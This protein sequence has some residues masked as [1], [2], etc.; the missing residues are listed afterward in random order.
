MA[1]R[2]SDILIRDFETAPR[3]YR[4]AAVYGPLV[5]ELLARGAISE[6]CTRPRTFEVVRTSTPK[7]SFGSKL[8]DMLADATAE[9]EDVPAELAAYW[10]AP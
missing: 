3:S 6:T 9:L 2:S 4:R 5:D 8:L 7:S 1:S 10:W